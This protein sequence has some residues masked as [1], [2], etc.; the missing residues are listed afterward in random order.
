M[1][2]FSNGTLVSDTGV[3]QTQS[4]GDGQA[5]PAGSVSINGIAHTQT[6]ERYV[7]TWPADNAVQ[8]LNG[9]AVRNDGAQVVAESITPAVFINGIG[10]TARGETFVATAGT[11]FFMNGFGVTAAGALLV[12]NPGFTP[13]SLF[14]SGVAGAW[15]APDD[16]STLFQDSAGTTPVTAVEQ[17]VGLMLDKVSTRVSY[18]PVTMPISSYDGGGATTIARSGAVLTFTGAASG[19][20]I[21]F[22]AI[23]TA[24]NYAVSEFVASGSGSLL[25]Y[26]GGSPVTITLTGTPTAY[27]AATQPNATS[28]TIFRSNSAGTSA[29][30]TINAVYGIPGNHASQATAASRPVLR[31]RYN[32]LTYSEQF[33]NAAWAKNSSTVTA[34]TTI[35]PDGTTTA[36]LLTSTGTGANVQISGFS[37]LAYTISFYAKR[38][39]SDWCAVS[40]AGYFAYFD[41]TNGVT[42]TIGNGTATIT[43]VGSGWYR[44]TWTPAD[45][46]QNSTFRIRCAVANG[47]TTTTTEN[48]ILWGAQLAYGSSAGTYQ[49]IAAATDYATVGF[50]P[51]L[52]FDGVDDFL[53][54]A[55]VQ[56]A[57]PLTI[58]AGVNNDVGISNVGIVS[59]AQTDSVYK[60]LRDDSGSTTAAQDRNAAILAP[61]GITVGGNKFCLAQFETSLIT[62]QVNGGTAN[63]LANTN[64]FGTSANIFVGK[65][66]PAGLFSPARDYGVVITNTVLTAAEKDSL[67]NWMASKM[68]VTL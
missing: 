41:I 28:F 9:A 1:T 27:R 20:G 32:L 39:N 46:T 22:T 47:N 68:G 15:Y 36:D 21:R 38:G 14:T 24:D 8:Y 13:L 6:G 52:T 37:L 4:L 33:D 63:T 19:D 5:V 57:Y 35:A 53:G 30:I 55:Y 54:A 26:A 40:N 17:P 51:Y 31:A 49:R 56:S 48:V 61:T 25:V 66:R 58:T 16:F 34:N 18:D 64:A 23:T 44:C 3:M 67:K 50:A 62:H 12:S 11:P 43:S 2:G 45:T 7:T 42:G 60:Q 65:T 29:S 10:R 59:V